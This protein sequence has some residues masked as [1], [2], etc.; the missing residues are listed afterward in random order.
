M[1]TRINKFLASKEIFEAFEFLGIDK[2][3]FTELRIM[4]HDIYGLHEEMS[5]RLTT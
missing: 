1:K 3:R 2:V 4:Y 5:R